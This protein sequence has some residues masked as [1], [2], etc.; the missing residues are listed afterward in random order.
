MGIRLTP[1]ATDLAVLAQLASLETDVSA[2]ETYNSARRQRFVS[3]ADDSVQEITPP[4]LSGWAFVKSGS[5]NFPQ[6]YECGVVFFDVGGSLY[7]AKLVSVGSF[8]TN[9]DVTT[10][11]VTGTTGTDGRTTL[12]VQAGVIKIENRNGVTREFV[13][14]FIGSDIT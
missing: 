6:Y 2:I 7:V 3:V 9:F 8:S 14:E 13:I 10:S 4:S 12:A 5:D 1:Q 11:D